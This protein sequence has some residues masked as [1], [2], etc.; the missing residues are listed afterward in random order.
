MELESQLE[1]SQNESPQSDVMKSDHRV[2]LTQFAEVNPA[3][4]FAHL[5][6]DAQVSFIPMS[7]ASET[8]EWIGHQTRKLSQVRQG[9]TPFQEGDLL[10]AKITPCM[11]NGKG[12]HA[13]NLTNGVGFGSTEFHVL[14]A[15]PRIDPRFI[16]HWLQSEALRRKAETLMT[17]S[18]GQRRVPA[19]FFDRFEVPVISFAEQ[20]RIAEI[21]DTVDAAIQQTEALIAKLKQVKAG[22]L[23]DLLTRGLDK[24]GQL[25]D[26][27]AHPEQFKESPCGLIPCEWTSPSIDTLAFHVGS[28]VT[29]TGGSEV[30][31]KEGIVFVRSQNV[32]FEGLLLDD[33]AYI[34]SATH[35]RMRRSEIFPHDV[36]LNITGASIGRCCPVP[37]G[38]PVANVNQHVCAIRL[39]NATWA[40]A[41]YLSAVLASYIGQSQIDRLNA[42][43][44]RQGLNYLQLR[45]F[46]IPWPGEEERERIACFLKA[47]DE[48]IQTEETYW[49]K[50][51][52]LKKGLM[53][54]LLTGKVRVAS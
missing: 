41:T 2:L 29:P 40:N 38:F 33:V 31:K 14:R 6:P 37:A 23:H 46:V 22:L 50:L 27:V 52:P 43:G 11:E 13:R 26:S 36:L 3:A 10:F 39:P 49:E 44:N 51:Q 28:G 5:P 45:S 25:R 54:D 30:Y 19:E 7:D 12:C 21:L 35:E 47:H 42:G 34:N 53:D 48:R 17:G 16:Y 18:A 4:A 15:R 32:T 1:W 20:R 9:Y 24:H 8:G